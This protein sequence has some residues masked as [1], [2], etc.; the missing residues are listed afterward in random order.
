[1][2]R[3]SLSN[4]ERGIL[5]FK[6]WPNL[7]Y[8]RRM[9]I[10][11][12]LI[13]LG[14]LIQWITVLAFPG[15]LVL[16]AGNVLLLVTGYHNK[17]EFGSYNP[18]AQW[19]KVRLERLD[20]L[21]ELEKNIRRWDR[22]MM[23]ISNPLGIV[24]FGVLLLLLF[25]W[26]TNSHGI[27]YII[28]IDTAALLLPHWLTGFRRMLRLP[29]LMVKVDTIKDLLGS[30]ASGSDKY[31]LQLL[32]LLKGSKEKL[33][34]DLK[35][36]IMPNE[37]VDNFLGL[38]GQVVINA[39]QG[40]SYPYFY[41]VLVTEKGSKLESIF[42]H[43]SPLSGIISEFKSQEK[44]DVFIVRQKTS[45]TSGYHTKPDTIQRIFR[46]GLDLM[47]RLGSRQKTQ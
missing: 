27:S 25:L 43:Y 44:V 15:V 19:Q 30:Q 20:E 28:A 35:I 2:S 7:D 11:F 42:Q 10:S 18:A 34:E 17:V 36:K 22:S 5:V 39:V 26:A 14:F 41:V 21:I 1:M 33:P 12:A 37:P 45:K 8:R 46:E 6:L 4:D 38:Y 29:G 47:E 40:K 23:D 32:T 9:Q 16:L 3:L 24:I 31:K 13:T